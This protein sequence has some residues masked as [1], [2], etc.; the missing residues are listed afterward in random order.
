VHERGK[1]SALSLD[2]E[3]QGEGEAILIPLTLT[4][5]L[6]GRENLHISSPLRKKGGQASSEIYSRWDMGNGVDQ[7]FLLSLDGRGLR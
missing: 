4:L 2:E 3:K 6:Q 5:S 1:N 7:I